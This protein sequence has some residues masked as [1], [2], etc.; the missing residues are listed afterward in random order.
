MKNFKEGYLERYIVLTVK[1]TKLLFKL[2]FKIE[3]G[4]NH[5]SLQKITCPICKDTGPQAYTIKYC[6]LKKQFINNI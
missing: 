1:I 4:L 3:Q 2:L 6:P 5:M